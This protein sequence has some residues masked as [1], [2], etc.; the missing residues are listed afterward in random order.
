MQCN[1][2]KKAEMMENNCPNAQL[3]LAE[4]HSW[5]QI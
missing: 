5:Q 2:K 1:L 3:A 4:N